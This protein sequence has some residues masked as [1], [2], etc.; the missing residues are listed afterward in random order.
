MC[1]D[2]D[3]YCQ[4]YCETWRRA[5]KPHKCASC[6]RVIGQGDKYVDVNGIDPEGTPFRLRACG[7]CMAQQDAIRQA[8]I[9]K[10]CPNH[11]AVC[12]IEEIAEYVL[13]SGME[14]V[15][16]EVAAA[17]AASKYSEQRKVTT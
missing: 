11:S 14:W 4:A 8:E 17:F 15:S 2:Y 9:A 6:R 13:D 12:A 3:A 10:G 7:R 5:R 16:D 1:F